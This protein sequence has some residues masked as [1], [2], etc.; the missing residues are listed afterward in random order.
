MGLLT[1]QFDKLEPSLSLSVIL[2]E[3]EKKVGWETSCSLPWGSEAEQC[4]SCPPHSQSSLSLLR[5][6]V[7][8]PPFSCC[9]DRPSRLQDVC[10]LLASLYKSCPF[11]RQL[12]RV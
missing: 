4:W 10:S 1:T 5:S 6:C 9:A 7:L 8:S 2:L 12:F 11:T 3:A